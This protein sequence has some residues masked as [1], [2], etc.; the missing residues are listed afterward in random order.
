M[1]P[2]RSDT[3]APELPAGAHPPSGQRAEGPHPQHAAACDEMVRLPMH[4]PVSSL[5]L[6]VAAGAM[7]YEMLARANG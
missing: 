2:A 1:S 7:L 4:G 3:T 5:N 6:A